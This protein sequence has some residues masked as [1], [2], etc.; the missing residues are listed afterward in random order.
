[1]KKKQ[2]LGICFILLVLFTLTACGNENG[3]ITKRYTENRSDILP[4]ITQT[5]EQFSMYLNQQIIPISNSIYTLSMQAQQLKAGTGSVEAEIKRVDTIVNDVQN[6][7]EDIMDL[8]LNQNQEAKRQN[9]I[10]ALT[11][12]KVQL[13]SYKNVLYSE[14]L[15]K[16]AVQNAVD[17]IMSALE[18]VKQ[19]TT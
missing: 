3:P 14:N 2:L 8:K 10:E 16:A 11:N 9:I 13:S 4:D 19:Y 1:M 18:T 5:D 7:I 17:I 6:K 12:L 15:T